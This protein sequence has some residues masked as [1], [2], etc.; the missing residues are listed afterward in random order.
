MDVELASFCEAEH[1][2][3]VGLLALYVGERPVAE[4]SRKTRWHGCVSTGR[5][6]AGWPTV[7]R[8]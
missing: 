7:V 2:R 5:G 3:L 6:S 4:S 1:H 8:G